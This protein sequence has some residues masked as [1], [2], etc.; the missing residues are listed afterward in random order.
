MTTFKILNPSRSSLPAMA[1]KASASIA[2][3][4]SLNLLFFTLVSSQSPPSPMPVSATICNP[5]NFSA[6]ATV[7]GRVF[8]NAT[9][10]S[11]PGSQCCSNIRGL[12]RTDHQVAA[13]LCI[14][15]RT[16]AMGVDDVN[17]MANE[18]NTKD[19]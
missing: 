11:N 7:V 15:L 13:C 12:G 10:L 9:Q 19:H 14:A 18:L 16:N 6:C 2:F 1:S 3:L 8:F 17:V 4:L 5:V